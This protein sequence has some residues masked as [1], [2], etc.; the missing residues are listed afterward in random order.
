MNLKGILT[1]HNPLLLVPFNTGSEY[2]YLG[3]GFCA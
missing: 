3:E 1:E 2:L